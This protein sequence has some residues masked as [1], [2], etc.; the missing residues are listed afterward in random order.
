VGNGEY[1]LIVKSCD[2]FNEARVK[3]TLRQAMMYVMLEART[4]SMSPLASLGSI[5]RVLDYM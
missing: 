5:G 2:T 4:D 1:S 3:V